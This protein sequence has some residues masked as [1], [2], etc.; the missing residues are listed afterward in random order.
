MSKDQK[1]LAEAKHKRVNSF[2]TKQFPDCVVKYNG[3]EGC[4]HTIT[5]HL[6]TKTYL[7]TKTCKKFVRSGYRL[8]GTVMFGCTRPGFFNIDDRLYKSPYK[9]SQHRDLVNLNGWYI[10]MIN[11]NLFGLPAKEITA[12][13]RENKR[14]YLPWDKIV[15]VFNLNWLEK[16]KE[17][18]YKTYEAKD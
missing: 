16:L 17:Q 4:D 2:L 15:F 10:F 3:L 18:V 9:I 14:N 7:E 13:I 11:Y 5:N 1:V 8:K 12:F 6:G